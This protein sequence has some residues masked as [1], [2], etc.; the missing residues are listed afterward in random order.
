[1]PGHIYLLREREFIALGQPVYKLGKTAQADGKRFSGYPK[2]SEIELMLRVADHDVAERE[3]IGLFDALFK[4]RQD[5]GR[6]YYEGEREAMMREICKYIAPVDAS[7]SADVKGS[8]VEIQAASAV[9]QVVLDELQSAYFALYYAL[10]AKLSFTYNEL[11]IRRLYIQHHVD[12]ILASGGAPCPSED[13]VSVDLDK[14]M[15]DMIKAYGRPGC[16]RSVSSEQYHKYVGINNSMCGAFDLVVRYERVR[17]AMPNPAR[18]IA[19]KLGALVE[20]SIITYGKTR[21]KCNDHKQHGT[22]WAAYP[23]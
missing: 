15:S 13:G 6:E 11:S 3:L 16:A 10:Y 7:A 19:I 22:Q 1:M 17:K 2:G 9:Q 8:D 4:N 21:G 14:F 12:K 18:Y 23:G 5:I 20:I